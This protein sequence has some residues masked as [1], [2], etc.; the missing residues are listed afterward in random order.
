MSYSTINTSAGGQNVQILAPP[1]YVDTCVPYFHGVGED[2]TAL[3]TD[4][5]KTGIVD[6]LT[7]NGILMAAGN[8]A[9][10]NWGNQASLDANIAMFGLL[11]STYHPT[12]YVFFSQSMGG[13]AGLLN[14]AA[15]YAHLMGWFGIYPVCSLANMFDNNAGMFASNIRTAFGIA[16]DGSDYAAKTAGHDPLLVSA[17]A[18]ANLPMQF[19]ASPDDTVVNMAANTT[20][21]A[22]HCHP[23]IYERQVIVCTGNHG[24]PSHFQ[25]EVVYSFIIR[26]TVPASVGWRAA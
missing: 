11:D 12:K 14:A 3:T 9:G 6:L 25:P 2:Q 19:F 13:C 5:L 8:A 16:S 26:C 15:G 22:A 7:D 10:D 18:Y 21:M 4:S 20:A 24:D 17:A 1:N 23:S